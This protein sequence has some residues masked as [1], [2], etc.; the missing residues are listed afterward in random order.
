MSS[1]LSVTK[2]QSDYTGVPS[3]SEPLVKTYSPE[4]TPTD[5]K[6]SELVKKYHTYNSDYE[7]PYRDP[8][9][10]PQLL[11]ALLTECRLPFAIHS[12]NKYTQETENDIKSIVTLMPDTL[13]CVLGRLK[14]RGTV[15][16]LVAACHNEHIPPH[17][18]KFLIENGA[19]PSETVEVN[20]K[21]VSIVESLLCGTEK[22]YC[23]KEE[24]TEI[25]KDLARADAIKKI[26]AEFSSPKES[27]EES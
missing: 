27:K 13:H 12:I 22:K 15:T 20:G 16:P 19:D 25:E 2:L 8:K 10:R 21:P 9:G 3:T 11:D 18:I 7:H 5:E 23:T 17:I 6:I 4:K 26:F 14:S 1:L 24:Q